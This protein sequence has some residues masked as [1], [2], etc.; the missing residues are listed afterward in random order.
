M[1]GA[2]PTFPLHFYNTEVEV[3]FLYVGRYALDGI[4]TRYWLEGPGIESRLGRGFQQS[5]T[6]ALG[7]TQTPI[8]W[9]RVSLSRE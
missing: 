8:K 7:P 9:Y 5:S 6:P 1:S 3:T 4:T 2:L